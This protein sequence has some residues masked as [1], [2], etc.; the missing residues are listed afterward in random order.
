MTG[1]AFESRREFRHFGLP[2][3]Q[4]P[5][6]KPSRRETLPARFFADAESKY[7]AIVM[8]AIALHRA[9]RPVLIGSR[10]VRNSEL[11]AARFAAEGIPLALLN[12][13]QDR[14]EADIIGQAGLRSEVTIATNMAGRGTDIIL[15][16][17]VAELGGMHVIGVECH[18]S[19]RIDRQL[20]GRAGRQGNPGSGRFFVSADDPLL[21]RYVPRLAE[22]MRQMPN[23]QG[24]IAAD[25]SREVLIAQHTAA[26][27]A[28]A[29]RRQMLEHDR[30][31]DDL[32]KVLH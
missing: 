2:V 32:T 23:L 15:G 1:T 5:L 13:K 20:L 10:T 4:I 9:G 27:A 8:E 7:R 26:S 21:V 19:P 12:G 11:L 16:Q 30:W 3:V 18:E 22:R 14:A 6:Q 17:G 29:A 31:I 24:E 28:F 25:L